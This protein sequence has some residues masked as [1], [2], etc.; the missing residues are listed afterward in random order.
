MAVPLGLSLITNKCKIYGSSGMDGASHVSA[1]TVK[2]AWKKHCEAILAM[3][4]HYPAARIT[5]DVLSHLPSCFKFPSYTVL[6]C[7]T[8]R[9]RRS[10]RDTNIFSL[11][12]MNIITVEL[13]ASPSNLSFRDAI[14]NGFDLKHCCISLSVC[15]N[16]TFQYHSDDEV[17]T[18]LR[19]REAAAYHV[20][21]SELQTPTDDFRTVHTYL[22]IRGPRFHLVTRCQ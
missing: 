15:E 14:L 9:L 8:L 1:S 13:T 4:Q 19:Q 16:L 21:L 11:L 20:I 10:Q 22:Q 5:A 2:Q 6:E 17:K 7:W 12:P 3:M 18:L